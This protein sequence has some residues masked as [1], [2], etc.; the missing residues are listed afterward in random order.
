MYDCGTAIDLIPL[1]YE[2]RYRSQYHAVNKL[3]SDSHIS[4]TAC[5]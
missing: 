5:H 2:C 4:E 3:E 1:H